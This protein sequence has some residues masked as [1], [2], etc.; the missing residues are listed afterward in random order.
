MRQEAEPRTWTLTA[1]LLAVVVTAVLAA[2]QAT[3]AHALAR[4]DAAKVMA[5][6]RHALGGAD[7]V[8]AVRTLTAVG[9]QRRM[10]AKGTT[11]GESEFAMELPDKFL[12]RTALSNLGSMSTFVTTGFN[13]DGAI[14][15][16]DAPPNLAGAGGKAKDAK[17]ALRNVGDAGEVS[18]EN[19]AAA[20]QKAVLLAKQEFARLA[21][22]FLGSAYPTFPLEFTYVAEADSPDGTAH[23]IEAHG[24]GA[25]AVR[26]FVDA[27]TSLPLM[28]QWIQS[29]P[30]AKGSPAK[31]V[32]HTA[33]YSD[34]REVGDLR[35]PHRL[36]RS[37]GAVPT[38][39]TVFEKIRVNTKIDSKRFT[40]SK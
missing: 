13:G 8:A 22:G 29:Y 31:A 7:K 33:Y 11:E 28:M 2:G 34:F 3:G 30:A 19:K 20:T 16:L 26:L 9:T 14:Y 1:L 23:V 17:V 39:D 5:D 10:A 6:L 40:I 18:A 32:E 21:L 4:T 36:Q 27:R 15:L 24:A 12:S 25:F 37:V 38:E 35:L